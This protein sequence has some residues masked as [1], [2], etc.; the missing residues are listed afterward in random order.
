MGLSARY[1]KGVLKKNI[2]IALK[3]K[4]R[5]LNTLVYY[6][7]SYEAEC[8]A[9]KKSDEK[10]IQGYEMWCYRRLLRISWTDRITNEEVLQRI[11]CQERL[12]NTL[13]AGN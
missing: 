8:W 5:I 6:I 12:L 13:N 11:N 9:L 7:A 1:S 2:S 10:R 3:T 4:M